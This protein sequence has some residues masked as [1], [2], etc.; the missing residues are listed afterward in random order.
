MNYKRL[1]SACLLSS[2]CL[3]GVFTVNTAHAET[4]ST[5]YRYNPAGGVLS[6]T[7]KRMEE[8]GHSFRNQRIALET[9]RELGGA[10]ITASKNYP[11]VP[12]DPN[13]PN[14]TKQ[15]TATITANAKK[16]ASRLGRG[17]NAG[18]LALAVADLVGEGVDWVLDPENN[19]IRYQS[20]DG[21]MWRSTYY[22]GSELH[23]TPMAA[24]NDN[25]SANHN[26][27]SV[28]EIV[29][30][31]GDGTNYEVIGKNKAGSNMSV[32]T[33][34]KEKVTGEQTMSLETVAQHIIN[35]D[36]VNN[37]TNN[38]DNSTTIINN[39]YGEAVT[40][41]LT[42]QIS[43]GDHDQELKKIYDYVNTPPSET[44]T[45]TETTG[46]TDTKIDTETKT[47]TD[48]SGSGEP[49]KFEFPAFCDWAKPVCDWF[50]WTKEE[51][52][53]P[54]PPQPLPKPTLSDLGVEDNRFEKRVEF[55]GSCPTG[56]F[57]FVALGVTYSYTIPYR[58]FCDLLVM[59]RPW[60]LA[61]TYLST[62]YY[63]LSNL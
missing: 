36:T 37:T 52:P 49:P 19:S 57:S 21:Y 18:A 28:I 13:H 30:R 42:E 29:D 26:C 62:A 24:A 44:D 60:L 43:K 4:Y 63:V 7:E 46:E 2:I 32:W 20:E 14:V 40:D 27:T 61:F 12:Y 9:Q 56:V 15:K 10:T 5:D 45:E 53:E 47:D 1:L 25:C 54:E 11:I 31:W 17:L 41:T 38:T 50:E 48:G 23:Y 8:M 39:Y 51:P 35:N 58:H 55:G 34:T 6:A 22:A 33:I 59:L 16:L 3:G